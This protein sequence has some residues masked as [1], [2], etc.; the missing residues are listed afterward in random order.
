M[1]I[2][3]YRDRSEAASGNE[4]KRWKKRCLE[5]IEQ[6]I[7][8]STEPLAKLC[9]MLGESVNLA[10][11]QTISI[12]EV[13]EVANSV[14]ADFTDIYDYSAPCFPESY[15]I[16]NFMMKAY[17][18]GFGKMIDSIGELSEILS[19]RQILSVISWI[20]QYQS[21]IESLGIETEVKV[22]K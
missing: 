14:A 22:Q 13:L 5:E 11:T 3:E 6:A 10:V 20:T 16:F 1:E 8:N 9:Q 4:P 21:Y 15:Q 12:D 2:Q 7:E 17:H 18:R 19:N